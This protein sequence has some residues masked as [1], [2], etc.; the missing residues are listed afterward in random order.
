MYFSVLC[1][2]LC[3]PVNGGIN[4]ISTNVGGQASYYCD[5][6]YQLI[7]PYNRTCGANGTW[8][9]DAPYCAA[10]GNIKGAVTCDFK[11]CG[12]LTSVDSDEPVQPPFK[13]RNS[14]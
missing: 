5:D 13:L 11:Q 9:D 7:G 3:P 12:I 14:K 2:D 1:S 10:I 8:S 6:N 4:M